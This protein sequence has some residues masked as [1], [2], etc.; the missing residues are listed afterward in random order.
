MKTFCFLVSVLMVLASARAD[1]EVMLQK[2]TPEWT[3]EAGITVQTSQLADGTIG[4]TFTRYLNR[5]PGFTPDSNLII[6][7][8]A[9]LEVR[10]RAGALLAT[11]NVAGETKDSTIIYSFSSARECIGHSRFTLHEYDDYKDP[12]LQGTYKGT[13]WAYEVNLKDFSAPIPDR[14]TPE[15]P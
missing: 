12:Q 3:K 5:A 10:N 2:V 4:F 8:K 7:R 13:R 6:A 14:R 15:H 9:P 11:T 1:N